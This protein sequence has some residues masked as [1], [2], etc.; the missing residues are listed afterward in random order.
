MWMIQRP[1]QPWLKPSSR[2]PSGQQEP[3][4]HLHHEACMFLDFQ[5]NGVCR[6]VS[7][8][9]NLRTEFYPKKKNKSIKNKR[10]G[11]KIQ[12]N[13]KRTSCYSGATYW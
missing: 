11:K 4:K 2:C 6:K 12:K 13:K 5:Q 8:A 3:L 7:M 10:G 1:S 9:L